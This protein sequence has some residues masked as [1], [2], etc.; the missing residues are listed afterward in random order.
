MSDVN[1]YFYVE[2]L[3]LNA[4]QKATLVD[5]LKSLGQ[6]NN[7]GNPRY[8]NH[9]RTRTDNDAVIF[10]GVF[11]DTN[12]TAVNVRNRLAAIFGVAQ[13]T[14]TYA[15]NQTAYGPV[16]TFTYSGTARLRLG[17]F[18]GIAATYKESQTQALRFLANYSEQ[19]QTEI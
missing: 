12:L 8:R 5:Q 7:D 11:D 10:E 1:L 17:V 13:A 16:V 2:N 6:R 4:A 3:A 9:W 15:T 14:I 19:W 18:G